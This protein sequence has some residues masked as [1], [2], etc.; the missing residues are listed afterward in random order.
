MS[1]SVLTVLEASNVCAI[2]DLAW[3][4]MEKIVLV[5]QSIVKVSILAC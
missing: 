4:L 2:K 5:C 1:R 3:T